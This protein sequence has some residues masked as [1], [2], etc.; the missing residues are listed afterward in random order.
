MKKQLFFCMASLCIIASHTFSQTPATAPEKWD[1]QEDLSDEFTTSPLNTT[2]WTNVD[3]NCSQLAYRQ[4]AN[5]SIS[6][7]KL[8]LNAKKE[9]VPI[10]VTCESQSK[11]FNYS[12]GMVGSKTRFKYGYYEIRFKLPEGNT[13]VA[14]NFWF[15]GQSGGEL[16]L[17][18]REIDVFEMTCSEPHEIPITLHYGMLDKHQYI[19]SAIKY[20]PDFTSG[21][22]TMGLEW[23]PEFLKIYLDDVL[24]QEFSQINGF[25][26]NSATP[27]PV[28]ILDNMVLVLDIN[29]NDPAQSGTKMPGTLPV[30]GDNHYYEI[31]FF[32]VY[33]RKPVITPDEA[34]CN[35]GVLTF[36]ASRYPEDEFTWHP[37]PNKVDVLYVNGNTIS[38][39]VK[40][41]YQGQSIDLS[42]DADHT[43]PPGEEA[44]NKGESPGVMTSATIDIYRSLNSDF[45]VG[46][47]ECL[48]KV[49]CTPEIIWTEI[50][51]VMTP[52]LTFSYE[53]TSNIVLPVEALHNK[54]NQWDIY[55]VINDVPQAVPLQSGWGT[56]F[57]FDQELENGGEY[58]IK[59][60]S[61]FQDCIE[62]SETRKI[63]NISLSD[64][65][66]TT[67]ECNG[68]WTFSATSNT[69]GISGSDW[70]LYK[71]DVYG[72]KQSTT[73]DYMFYGPS[74]TFSALVP[75]QYYLLT[76]GVY[77][78]CASSWTE[79]SKII[80]SPSRSANPNFNIINSSSDGTNVKI[81]ALA[82][83]LTKEDNCENC[84]HQWNLYNSDANGN[85]GTEIG[86][87]QFGPAASFTIPVNTYYVIKHGV[88]NNC[89]EW[90]ERR[91][92]GY[93]TIA[94]PL[95]KGITDETNSITDEINVYPNPVSEMLTLVGD[96]SS[97]IPVTWM[98]TDILGKNIVQ[99][100]TNGLTSEQ[101]DV[102]GLDKGIYL[103]RVLYEDKV[104]VKRISVN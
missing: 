51:G 55:K 42:V 7:D 78:E 90:Q 19:T 16:E 63:V 39:M 23:D 47:P 11:S 74:A 49:V 93:N 97:E 18:Y 40:P 52:T 2:L 89:S 83:G 8:K 25:M 56:T 5:V 57:V 28:S 61:Y 79:T 14:P 4:A 70:S 99:R 73:P 102:S 86:S 88:Y 17:N 13:M 85:T 67:P 58:L 96:I 64:F 34:N 46:L 37:D 77:G 50:N 12:T 103:V 75:D 82:R 26:D 76:H 95:R 92:L 41:A 9:S 69:K 21:F 22:H 65:T 38:L 31:D 68:A 60:G 15:W 20:G 66:Y 62:W 94:N 54:E 32:K 81:D 27:V 72:T 87:S 104:I 101:I 36:I 43:I 10:V 30:L 3:H 35:K 6:N 84:N 1:Y 100:A 29:L 33:K 91:F 98:L 45:K 24:I 48:K 53:I 59:H 44:T 71:C 80:Y